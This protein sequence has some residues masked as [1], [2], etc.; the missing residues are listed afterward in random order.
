MADSQEICKVEGEATTDAY[1]L[2]LTIER[3]PNVSKIAIHLA[4]VGDSNGALYKIT[5]G[6]KA[7]AEDEITKVT[8]QALA[9]DTAAG[10][11]LSDAWMYIYVYLKSAIAETPASVDIIASGV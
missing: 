7:D 4:E 9:A 6:N 5:V 11:V 10:E 8:D 3:P 1:V 2:A